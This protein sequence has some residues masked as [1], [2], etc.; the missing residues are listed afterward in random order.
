M[1][2]T[3]KLVQP[4]HSAKRQTSK[5]AE[6]YHCTAELLLATIEDNSIDIVVT[7]PPYCMGMEYEKSTSAQDFLSEHRKI[8]PEIERVLRPGGS[9][10]WQV[11]HHVNKGVVTPLDAL[12]YVAVTETTDLILRNRI[13]WTFGHGLHAPSRFSGRHESIL[14]FTKGDGH[15]FDLDAV[16]VPQKYPGKRHYKGD[17]KGQF[18]GNPL[19]KNPGDVWDIP[20]VKAKHVEK[21]KHPCQFPVATPRRLIR[22]LTKKN[23]RVLD[24]YAGSGSTAVAAILEGRT[25]IGSDT[26]KKYLEIAKRRVEQ[27]IKGKCSVR[28]DTPPREPKSNEAVAKIPSHFRCARRKRHANSVSGSSEP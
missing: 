15:T 24:P 2:A 23:A 16:R 25:F 22:A 8:F 7:S 28:A 1:N 20:N 12:V 19:G 14:W 4:W 18:S 27:S 26:E 9:A 21:T 13:V 5:I 17:R 6:L 11:G 3:T 10:C